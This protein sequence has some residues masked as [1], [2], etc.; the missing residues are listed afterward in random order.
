[1]PASIVKVPHHGS[2]DAHHDGIWTEL[3]DED[4][5]AVVTPLVR[6]G[7]KLPK[8]EDLARLAGI[9]R[10][11]YV[12]ADPGLRRVRDSLLRRVHDTPLR[13]LR[14]WGQVRARRGLSEGEWR[15]ELSGDA[16]RV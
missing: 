6:G 15:V 5:I 14:G 3:A 2:E 1:M 11:L 16:R 8:D 12:T 13:E 4:A 9:T 7:N 10:N